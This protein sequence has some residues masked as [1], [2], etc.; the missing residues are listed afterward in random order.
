MGTTVATNALLEK[1]GEK[2]AFVVTKGFRDLLHI[3]NQSR[4]KMFDLTI[5]KPEVLYEKVVEINERVTLEAWT[6]SR[7]Q[8]KIDA[9]SDP[10]FVEGV[11]GE[12]IRVLEPLDEK[13]ARE[14]LQLAYDEGYRSVAV[15]LM[16]SYTFQDHEL[17]VGKIAEEIGFTH[18]S[19]SSQLSPTVKIVPRG[20]S[21]TADAYLTP[22]IKRYIEGFESGFQDL[23]TS[24]CRCEFMQS[25]GGLV[26]FSRYDSKVC[27][28]TFE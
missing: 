4:P 25:D 13:Q 19:L 2:T 12:I 21:A 22:E 9:T 1:K 11:T 23:K 15:A 27:K 16:H 14:S 5:N 7:A 3:G 28:S 20:D 6:E 26:E 24:G 17:A 8:R 18:I 10:S